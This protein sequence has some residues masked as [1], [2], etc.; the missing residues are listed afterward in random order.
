MFFSVKL[1][2]NKVKFW[3]LRS[4]FF[5]FGESG[6]GT[7]KSG[8]GNKFR[9]QPEPDLQRCIHI[10]SPMNLDCLIEEEVESP[11][12]AGSHRVGGHTPVQAPHT[13]RSRYVV[14][15][16][17]SLIMRIQIHDRLG[18][19]IRI[20]IQIQ[21][22]K[23][24]EVNLK[25]FEQNQPGP[26][27]PFLYCIKNRSIFFPVFKNVVTKQCFGAEAGRSRG[28]LARDG[29]FCRLD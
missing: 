15:Y 8:S 20:R 25:F 3:Y 29:I 21:I 14:P 28:F 2:P 23:V 17:R 27:T 12:A 4:L 19:S 7:N 10:V 13:L 1:K 24:R 6:F 26:F 11:G 5:I 22:V 16:T 9:I 18:G